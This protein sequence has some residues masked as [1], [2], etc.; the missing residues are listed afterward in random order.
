MQMT[1]ATFDTWVKDTRI[2]S[3]DDNKLV[4]GTKS[5]L[6]KDWLENRLLTTIER[7]V[8]SI[9]GHPVD[10][11]FVVVEAEADDTPTP[12]QP[13]PPTPTTPPSPNTPS[14][15]RPDPTGLIKTANFDQLWQKSGFT[16][17]QDYAIRYWRMWLG[18]SFDLWEF[19]ISEDKRDV[20]KMRRGEIPYWTPP[21][22]Y[23][24]NELSRVLRCSRKTLTGRFVACGVYESQKRRAREKGEALP[25][26]VCC[27][28][29]HP[30][31]MRPCLSS[32][33]PEEMECVHWLEGLLERL[34]REGFVAVERV[35][36]PGRPRAHRLRLQ[37]WRLLPTLTPFQVAQLCEVDRV[38]HKY[39]IERYGRHGGFDL[40]DW[41][42]ETAVSLV[43]EMPGY[44]WGRQLFDVYLN[45][46]LVKKT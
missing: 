33:D 28:K 10:L 24:Y 4:V 45:N 18:R 22:R 17:M 7:T 41:E 32:E 16:Q 36:T 44:D 2:V 31:K 11:Q 30:H 20:K 40:G 6:A 38:K 46:P 39:W 14:P 43:P 5:A 3:R 26:A 9:I 25:E 29:H 8:T 19:L 37:A 21:K 1:Q 42:E 35:R 34:Y 27:G 23:T 12:E 13:T 15:P